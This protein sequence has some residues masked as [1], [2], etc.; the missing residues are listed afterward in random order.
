VKVPQAKAFK[1]PS[2]ATPPPLV[3]AKRPSTT[4]KPKQS[5]AANAKAAE[6][7]NARLE[8]KKEIVAKPG[9]YTAESNS[10][11]PKPLQHLVPLQPRTDN[12]IS[13]QLERIRSYQ[14]TDTQQRRVREEAL[15]T[16]QRLMGAEVRAAKRATYDDYR[17]LFEHIDP[18]TGED[19]ASA[20]LRGLHAMYYHHLNHARRVNA[21]LTA[22]EASNDDSKETADEISALQSLVSRIIEKAAYWNS[23]NIGE[24][25]KGSEYRIVA[26]DSRRLTLHVR[27]NARADPEMWAFRGAELALSEPFQQLATLAYELRSCAYQLAPSECLSQRHKLERIRRL[28]SHHALTMGVISTDALDPTYGVVSA[29]QLS[30]LHKAPLA[31]Q[32]WNLAMRQLR[33]LALTDAY[34]RAWYTDATRWATTVKREH[35]TYHITLPLREVLE[36]KTRYPDVRELLPTYQKVALYQAKIEEEQGL[37]QPYAAAYKE[38]IDARLERVRRMARMTK[39]ERMQQVKSFDARSQAWRASILPTV[40]S[41]KLPTTRNRPSSARVARSAHLTLDPGLSFTPEISAS[42][43][44]EAGTSKATLPQEQVQLKKSGGRTRT[45]KRNPVA[46]V[47][48]PLRRKMKGADQLY[49]NTPRGEES[50]AAHESLPKMSNRTIRRQPS[51]DVVGVSNSHTDI[52]SGKSNTEANDIWDYDMSPLGSIN[53]DDSLTAQE[54]TSAPQDDGED[55]N[56]MQLELREI[57][58]RRRLLEKKKLKQNSSQVRATSGEGDLEDEDIALELREISIR[59]RMLQRQKLKRSGG[60]ASPKGAWGLKMSPTRPL[61]AVHPIVVTSAGELDQVPETAIEQSG[62]LLDETEIKAHVPLSFQIPNEALRQA[63]HASRSSEAAFWSY[64]LYRGPEGQPITVHYCT[65]IDKV[66]RVAEMFIGKAVLGFDI[67]WKPQAQRRD[68]IK[69]CVSLVQLA[70]DDRIAL[71]HL[72]LHRGETAEDLL[73]PIFKSILESPDV[74]KTGVAVKADCSRIREYLGVSVRGIMEL[75]HMHK[76]VK[77]CS[78]EPS[79]VDKRLVALAKQVE[80][81]LQLPLS[82]GEVRGSDWSLPLNHQQVVYAASDAY[83]GLRLF[84]ALEAKRLAL[85]PVPPRPAF[86]ELGLPIKL[87]KEAEAPEEQQQEEEAK[88][89]PEET[90]EAD[91]ATSTNDSIASSPAD[92]E[93]TSS[94]WMPTFVGRLRLFSSEDTASRTGAGTQIIE[95]DKQR[96]SDET[97]TSENAHEPTR[98][99]NDTDQIA[100]ISKEATSDDEGAKSPELC[101]ADAW[102]RQHRSPIPATVANREPK[103]AHPSHLRAYTLW[104]HQSKSLDEIS[105][106]LRTPPLKPT[107]VASYIM[108][109]VKE[110]DLPYERERLRS[111]LE[112]MP[113]QA[114]GRYSWYWKDLQ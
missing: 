66:E 90:E 100:D 89:H 51:F 33:E 45:I 96:Q 27:Y 58:L 2:L 102:L 46:R 21:M 114:K 47:T 83:A 68:G 44:A 110:E 32:K 73:G 5:L 18:S 104:H 65:T 77:H 24:F 82:K 40:S 95:A 15:A 86:A 7:A 92:I 62:E 74:I 4:P 6:I 88:E 81:H 52:T 80:E 38:E 50:R 59:R 54:P 34:L 36:L 23:I 67:E 61:R 19:G 112:A 22:C 37:L 29:I 69:K 49:I 17:E 94:S 109:A 42:V 111:V 11:K 72:A 98:R 53:R 64:K 55:E 85:D 70:A 20:L 14:E 71:F 25:E 87:A 99:A 56:D 108:E 48:K 60:S 39:R 35:P 93:S 8:Q 113:W 106:L 43:G 107:T 97:Q 30:L 16:A 76:L 13:S 63:M 1:E 41:S 31:Q 103:A 3:P 10:R 12:R 9:V 26:H 75:S 28:A 84:D 79:K 101:Q 105:A 78:T 57:K 91:E